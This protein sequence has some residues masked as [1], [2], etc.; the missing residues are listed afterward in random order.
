MQ[1]MLS[2]DGLEMQFPEKTLRNYGEFKEWYEGVT[3]VF[4]DQ[5]HDVKLLGIDLAGDK[6]TVNLIVNWQA[7]T[8][9]PPAPKS[10]W[11]GSNVHQKWTVTRDPKG[12]QAVI[13][14]YKVGTFDPM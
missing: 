2:G 1:A 12:G 13:Q 7:R 4:F 14:L 10:E 9:K 5:V 8:W 3:G 11:Q 6:A